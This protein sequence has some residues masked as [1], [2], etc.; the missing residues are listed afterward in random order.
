M[1]G[2]DRRE[3]P[4]LS[5]VLI[6]VAVA[7]MIAA[8]LAGGGAP[9]RS[10]PGLPASST[11][12]GW[13]VPVLRLVADGSA[14]A[15]T[16]CLVAVI[17]LLRARNGQLDRQAIR[18][19]RDA[20]VAAGVWSLASVGGIVVKAAVELG[21]PLSKLPAHAG[22]AA[23]LPQIAPLAFVAAVTA[24]LA[25]ML[26]GCHTIG[27]ARVGTVITALAVIA[28][29]LTGHAASERT[30]VR[31]VIATTSLM[32][33][34]LAVSVWIGGLAALVRYRG[35]GDPATVVPRYSR[36]ALVAA[37]ATA[38]SGVLTAVIHLQHRFVSAYGGLVLVKV[39]AL[40][41]LV[42]FGWRH[43]RRTLPELEPGGSSFRRLAIGELIV[44][45]ATVGVAVALAQAP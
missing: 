20:A 4:P 16:G 18:I 30:A 11:T 29:L 5:D 33:H 44:M 24:L 34:V 12:V 3:L 32:V 19:C 14:I 36:I 25:V 43:R 27:T 9:K 2:S 7:V 38:L 8:L 39:L 22:A 15:C 13:A 26:S 1:S 28:P 17:L 31:S 45:A 10:V 6:A 23:S 40:A 37:G 21:L 41:V 35:L 42:A